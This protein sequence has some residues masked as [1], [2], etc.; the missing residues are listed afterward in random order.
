MVIVRWKL[1][2]HDTDKDIA[3]VMLK[4]LQVSQIEQEASDTIA[5]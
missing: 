5:A 4:L 2:V 1:K 3:K